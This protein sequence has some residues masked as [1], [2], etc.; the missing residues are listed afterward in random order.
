MNNFLNYLNLKVKTELLES[1]GW[2]EQLLSQLE[3][4]LNTEFNNFHVV[5]PDTI[6]ENVKQNFGEETSKVLNELFKDQLKSILIH[7]GGVIDEH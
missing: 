1:L 5:H 4:Y 2:D 6:I 3:E 7:N